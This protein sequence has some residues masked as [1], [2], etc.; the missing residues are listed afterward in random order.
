RMGGWRTETIHLTERVQGNPSV[1]C[2]ITARNL[3]ANDFGGVILGYIWYTMRVSLF[4]KIFG[5]PSAH[6]TY[7][8]K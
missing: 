7:V 2:S 8:K 1:N 3:R 4:S 5:L 6:F